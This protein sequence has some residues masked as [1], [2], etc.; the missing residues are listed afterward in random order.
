MSPAS[1]RGAIRFPLAVQAA[2]RQMCRSNVS[3][4][5]ATVGHTVLNSAQI[6]Q[7][8]ITARTSLLQLAYQGPFIE[9]TH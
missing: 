9:M 4:P 6:R 1:S 7:A 5:A 2:S 8:A 3:P